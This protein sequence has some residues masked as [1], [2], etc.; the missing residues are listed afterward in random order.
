MRALVFTEG[1][2]EVQDLPDPKPGPGQVT[3]EV[4][5]CG[6][7]GT[8]HSLYRNQLLPEGAILGHEFAGTVVEVGRGIGDWRC[9]DRATVL[10]IPF[11]GRC[12]L[13]VSGTHNL[14]QEGLRDEIG[15]GRV[16]GGMAQFVAVPTR[17]LRRLP[18]SIDARLGAL[19]DPVSV[20]LH[21]VRLARVEPGTRVG[22]LGLGPLGLF[23]GMLA[24]QFGA[25][26]FGLDTR[27]ARVAWAHTIGLGAFTSD[28]RADERIRDLTNG[29]PDV[30]IEA[31]GR[32]ESIERAASLA[33]IGGQVVMVASYHAPAEIKPGSWVTRGISLLPSIAYT[34]DDFETA[35][36]LMTTRQIDAGRLVTSIGTLASVSSLFDRFDSQVDTLKVLIDPSA[37]GGARKG[38]TAS[39]SASA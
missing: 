23:A 33:R 9:G 20:A 34:P 5:T 3:L 2:L 6:I 35:L 25:M 19:V 16:P 10:P 26:V 29:G 12:E 32:P 36:E 17:M 27:A 38:G 14:C 24:R 30:V 39:A 18:Q 7:C 11:C 8:D 4:S 13:C 28:D 15:C 22:I 21:A 31:T 37:T 1:R